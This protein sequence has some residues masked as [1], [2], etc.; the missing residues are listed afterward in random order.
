MATTARSTLQLI[1]RRWPW[2]AVS[3][4][5]TLGLFVCTTL[6]WWWYAD[7]RDAQARRLTLD[8]LWLEQTLQRTLET[9]Q[10]MLVN[11]AEDLAAPGAGQ[12]TGA[13]FRERIAGLM[14]D[15]RALLAIDQV[16]AAGKRITGLPD[17]TERP[18]QLPPLTDPLIGAALVQARALRRPVYSQ[19]I[20]QGAPLWVLVVPLLDEA[21]AQGAVLAT[22]NLDR[23]LELEVPWWFVQ[24]YDLSLVDRNHKRLFPTDV[25]AAEPAPEQHTLTFGPPDSGLALQAG[26]HEHAQPRGLLAGLAA[27]AALLAVTLV[28]LLQLLRRW[29]RERAAAARMAHERD[30][31]LQH[32]ARLASL[33]ELASG[34]AH[35]LNQ[36]LAAIANYSA[37]ASAC[38]AQDPPLKH[39]AEDAVARMGEEAQR[40]GKIIHSLRSFIQKR[41]VEHRRHAVADLLTEPL[42]LLEPLAR[43]LQ[44]GIKVDA[45]DRSAQIDCDAV[46]IEQVV[47]N[48]LRNALE[49]VATQAATPPDDAVTVQ[50]A[51]DGEAVAICVADRGPGIAQPERLFQAFYTTKPEGMGLGLAICRTVV[52]S[53]GGRL[54]AEAN[55]G[56]GARV[57]VRLPR[58][59]LA[60]V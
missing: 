56:G 20:E 41:E 15:H 8:L 3:L 25:A 44:V 58:S 59:T 57:C 48:L 53:H 49:A 24:R 30:E 36:P 46:M 2:L 34:I 54:W 10:R 11:W 1:E 60:L 35:E 51:D 39:K 32:T 29:L 16:D 21:G 13:E 14:K 9:H 43:R 5:L 55:P 26:L 28:W 17:Y 42:A 23:L 7:Q 4:A 37:V 27:A 31:L 45:R 47:F 19:V 33:A 38:L 18:S 6:G 12:A 22:Y 52:E 40:A 50:V